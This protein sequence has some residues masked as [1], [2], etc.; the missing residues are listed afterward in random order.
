MRL[1]RRIASEV[2]GEE[3]S[4]R[5]W[6]GMDVVGDIAVIRKPFD[7]ELGALARLAEEIVRRIP[8]IRS[9]WA[10]VSPVR[11]E[12]RLR[13]L[14]HLAG[15]RRTE[16]VYKEHGCVF[17]V[18]MAKVYVSPR[19]SYEHMRVARLV[20]KGEEIMNM[21]AGAGLFSIIIA[22]HSSPSRIFSIDVNENAYRLMEENVRLN[23]VE[24][25]VIPIL[26]DSSKIIEG[27]RASADRILMPLPELA[28]KLL[29]K[30]VEALRGEGWIHVYDFARSPSKASALA[31]AEEIYSR[32]LSRLD[33][34]RSY[35]ISGSRVVR[36][37]GP[38]RYQVV[39]DIWVRS[40]G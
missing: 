19:L 27:F 29:P 39:L 3:L 28:Y 13:E 8:W 5:I 26:G 2:L 33:S 35:R 40:S 24:G 34:V 12:H 22:A 11:G 31:L 32:A 16:T 15:E 25:V 7:L 21:F 14:A 37:V 17:K 4:K 36:S 30:A 6:A 20:G 23:R 9:V 18:D 1:L 10:S 38:R